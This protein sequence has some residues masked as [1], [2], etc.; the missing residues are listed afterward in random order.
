MDLGLPVGMPFPRVTAVEVIS[1]YGLRLTFADGTSG[2]VDGSRWVQREPLGVFAPLRDPAT[3]AKVHLLPEPGTIGWPGDID[4]C[5]GVLY[6][7]AH[8]IALP[9]I[10]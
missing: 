6:A 9:G 3:F 7:P 8:D 1:P 2:I 10:D 4:L 5:P